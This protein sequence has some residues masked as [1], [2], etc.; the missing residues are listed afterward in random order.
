MFFLAHLPLARAL[1]YVCTLAAAWVLFP[2]RPACARAIP[3]APNPGIEASAR[4][5]DVV[6][7]V[8][9]LSGGPFRA[10]AWVKRL[11]H[12]KAPRIIELV[13]Y[14]SIQGNTARNGLAGG[15]KYILFLT[16]TDKP[17]VFAL[18]TPSA[19]RW[20]IQDSGVLLA[21]GDPPFSVPIKR[22]AL[23]HALPLLLEHAAQGKSPERAAAFIKEL[24]GK[25]EIEQRYLSVALAGLLR[26]ERTMPQVLEAAQ[27][28]LLRL[29]MTGMEALRRIG[30]PEARAALR[31]LLKDGRTVVVQEAVLG[32]VELED[33]GAVDA[34]L[35]WAS[36]ACTEAARLPP[37]DARRGQLQALV[38][39]V[40]ALLDRK[41]AL[42]SPEQFCPELLAL[43][44]QKDTDPALA[45]DLLYLVAASAQATHVQ[46]L[47]D[48]AE[49]PVFSQRSA[50]LGALTRATL[51]PV[52]NIQEFSAWWK[53]ARTGYGEDLRLLHARAAAKG[54]VESK[55][56]DEVDR[57]HVLLSLAAP[58]VA[59]EV[60]APM[61]LDPRRAS[62]WSAS[63]LLSWRSPL[64]VPFLL[65]RAVSEDPLE[66]RTA[67]EG[68]SLLAKQHPR[69]RASLAPLVRTAL[70][71][72]R[73]LT[74]RDACRM[75]TRLE[76][77]VAL[78]ALIDLARYPAA[79]EADE[80]ARASYA[81]SA[82]TLGYGVYELDGDNVAAI[83]RMAG[84]WEALGAA[85]RLAWVSPLSPPAPQEALDEAV[86]RRL[87]DTLTGHTAHPAEAA[88]GE[89][90]AYCGPQHAVWTRLLDSAKSRDRAYAAIGLS[91]G[92][93]ALAPKLLARLEDAS[94][95]TE[96]ARAEAIF[97]LG[98]LKGG[99][100]GAALV[101]W[102]H[103][104][105]SQAGRVWQRMGVL[106][107]GLA[108][109]EA[110]GL[111]CLEGLLAQA[112]EAERTPTSAL[113]AA[114]AEP[115][116]PL[117]VVLTALGMRSDSN[118]LL[119]K[120]LATSSPELSEQ[121]ARLLALRRHAPAFEKLFSIAAL[122]DHLVARDVGRLA[123]PLLQKANLKQMSALLAN[124]PDGARI[125]AATVLAGRPDIEH[126][127]ESLKALI[128]ACRDKSYL[129]RAHAAQA[130]GRL[131]AI[132]ALPALVALLEDTDSEVQA[133]A[134][135]AVAAL[136]AKDACKT[137]VREARLIVRRD[138]R[139][140]RAMGLGGSAEETA[141][142][143]RLSRSD[144]WPDREAGL[145][146]LG[147]SSH[148]EALQRILELFHDPDAAQ[149]TLAADAL[150]AQGSAG[151]LGLE[152][153]L[154][155]TDA[156][157]R[158]AAVHV[159]GRMNT[160]TASA[161]LLQ[162]LEDSDARVRALADWG[163][164][165]HTGKEAG[166]DPE[167]TLDTRKAATVKWRELVRP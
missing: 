147:V 30:S 87:E 22:Q 99:A 32:L 19:P 17:D 86:L 77:S 96:L 10:A 80:A 13:G 145:L 27:G 72:D 94:A 118:A 71:S 91:N 45:S 81:L 76:D 126:D 69:L 100:G 24:W 42:L 151:L 48:L 63:D 120:A 20:P 159:L 74:R 139:W 9:I 67:L 68:L 146:G 101:M 92:D 52:G 112:L 65:E 6:A 11:Y 50:A 119:V 109:G 33:L 61:L 46:S 125:M 130:L 163:L 53:E 7:E 135:E 21:L 39:Q 128:A 142:L 138:T 89:L 70:A 60:I 116:L 23:E 166:F 111:A 140:F 162:I 104:K 15:S 127:A 26:D 58:G 97:A 5:A 12:G 122:A 106:A 85:R 62:K 167:A 108:D 59:L 40:L 49:D 56:P 136:G 149:Q 25:N 55:L 98:T 84:W 14:N 54:V 8:E 37:A 51:R 143:L 131:R 123:E 157:K 124:G 137:A 43:A 31:D 3:P 57:L 83:R 93:K 73:Y 113:E 29:R 44:R 4:G 82:R 114:S 18:L 132:A 47:L 64:A 38:F 105:G 36:T 79:N 121:T 66:C 28:S 133:S 34:L 88:F 75:A 134:A 155:A 35:A 164:K 102:L 141:T 154:K 16:A 41:G 103:G 153:D 90:L 95:G 160:T 107:L 2:I 115:A 158:A 165:R 129:V 161:R 1:L 150:A 110:R 144:A 156:L 78:P 152:D 117:R 148:P